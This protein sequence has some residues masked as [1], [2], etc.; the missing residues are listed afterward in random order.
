MKGNTED[1][2]WNSHCSFFP[3][4]SVT[5]VKVTSIT[6]S[7]GRT[8][9][10]NVGGTL[11][12]YLRPG[13]IAALCRQFKSKQ[14]KMCQYQEK[15]WVPY[16]VSRRRGDVDGQSPREL[17]DLHAEH[18]RQIGHLRHLFLYVLVLRSL[19]EVL[20]LCYLANESQDLPTC[21]ATCGSVSK[22]NKNT[23]GT[24]IWK[25]FLDFQE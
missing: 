17:Q 3:I 20:R 12:L 23:N 7:M 8:W 10:S 16:P 1:V 14:V 9:R 21:A 22:Q 2:T 4:H 15:V 19:L 24:L 18:Q 13:G 25:C 11:K 5:W 6:P